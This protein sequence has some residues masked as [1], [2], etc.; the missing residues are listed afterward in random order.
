MKN[1]IVEYAK[2]K[3]IR[4]IIPSGSRSVLVGGCFDLVHYAHHTFLKNAKK[5]GDF[6]II[7]LESDDHIKK[8]KNRTPIHT[9]FERAEILSCFE[10]VDLVILIPFLNSDKQYRDVVFNIHPSVI[11]V[12]KGDKYY[13]KKSDYAHEVSGKIVEV[14]GQIPRFATSKIIKDLSS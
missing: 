8:I 12:T 11:A 7:L 14:T 13:D 5:Q 4:K 2:I 3:D 1:K 6:L 9:Q 10:Y